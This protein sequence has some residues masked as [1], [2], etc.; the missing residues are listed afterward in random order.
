MKMAKTKLSLR[1]S[2]DM[3]N[4]LDSQVSK[5]RF[6]NKTQ[7]I[8]YMLNYYK[9]QEGLKFEMPKQF[10]KLAADYYNKLIPFTFGCLST[11]FFVSKNWFFI[12]FLVIAI[13]PFMFKISVNDEIIKVSA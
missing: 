11:F 13:M 4:F 5:G 7:A 9:N 10:N 3:G 1:V 12:P 6:T 8:T 2:K